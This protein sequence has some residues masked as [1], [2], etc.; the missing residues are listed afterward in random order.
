MVLSMLQSIP[1]WQ[2]WTAAAILVVALW[3]PLSVGT[4]RHSS[5]RL[6]VPGSGDAGFLYL[7]TAENALDEEGSKGSDSAGVPRGNPVPC[8]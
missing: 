4:A 6:D 1:T 3:I 7:V 5:L 2:T 8:P